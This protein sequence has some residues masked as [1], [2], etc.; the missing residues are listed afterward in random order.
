MSDMRIFQT[1]ATRDVDHAKPDYEGFLSPRVIEAFG[2][3]MNHNRVTASGV[4][5][6]DNWQ[7]GM[8]RDVY[9]KSGWRHAFDWWKEH[10]GLATKEGLVWALCGLMFN[11]MGYLHEVLKEN[12]GLLQT[13]LA[14]AEARRKPT[15]GMVRARSQH[16]LAEKLG[17][18]EAVK[19]A[20]RKRR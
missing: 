20:A 16:A 14:A 11:V 1:G 18:T 6:S 3:Y 9:M 7:K 13:A 10:R 17:L 2:A 5:D 19:R 12:P 8:P 4:R 15:A